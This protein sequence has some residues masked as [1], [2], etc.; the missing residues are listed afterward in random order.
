MV[1][2]GPAAIIKAFIQSQKLTGNLVAWGYDWGGAIALKMG[3][4]YPKMFKKIIAVMPSYNEE[5]KDELK[6][7]KMPTLISWC[8]EDQMHNWDKWKTLAKKIPNRTE[9]IFSIKPYHG[10]SFYE[11]EKYMTV[12]MYKFLTGV[13]PLA[14][15]RKVTKGTEEA[16][17][18]T[19]G[20]KTIAVHTVMIADELKT[21]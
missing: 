18:S 7:L 15:P 11:G 16:V 19:G 10:R 2:G 9:N 5:E 1:E 6:Q 20:K 14:G 8:K 17:T 12:A 13:D 21:G 3:I 4:A